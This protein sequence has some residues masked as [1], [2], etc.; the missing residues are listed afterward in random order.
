MNLIM[1][2]HSVLSLALPDPFLYCATPQR[3]ALPASCAMEAGRGS[4]LL[5]LL[6]AVLAVVHTS[7]VQG[8]VGAASVAEANVM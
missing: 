5:R 1:T 8:I 2:H 6:S 3:K 4:G 7:P